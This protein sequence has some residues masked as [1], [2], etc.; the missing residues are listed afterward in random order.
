VFGPCFPRSSDDRLSRLLRMPVWAYHGKLD[1][2]VPF[3]ETDGPRLIT[4]LE[5]DPARSF[6][7][8]CAAS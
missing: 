3:E 7:F 6:S 8:G 4:W 2:V 1:T 5:H